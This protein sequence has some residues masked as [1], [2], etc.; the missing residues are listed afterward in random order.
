VDRR[1]D[2]GD[3]NIGL[4]L[5]VRLMRDRLRVAPAINYSKAL[6]RTLFDDHLY[7]AVTVSVH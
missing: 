3:A 7:W 6:D 2:V 1:V 4:T 5:S